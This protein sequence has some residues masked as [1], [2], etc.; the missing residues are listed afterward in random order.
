[1]IS[2]PRVAIIMLLKS[3]L[4]QMLRTSPL[5]VP[6]NSSKT[7]IEVMTLRLLLSRMFT[8]LSLPPVNKLFLSFFEMPFSNYVKEIMAFFLLVIVSSDGFNAC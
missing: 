1:M 5:S 6:G 2:H 7:L 3:A 8:I 4:G